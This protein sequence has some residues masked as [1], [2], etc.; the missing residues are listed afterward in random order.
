MDMLNAAWRERALAT[1]KDN[2]AIEI[3]GNANAA[4]TLPVFSFRVKD[5]ENSGYIHQQLVTR[6][7]SDVYGVQARGGCACAG[8]YAHR[9]LGIGKDES[10][11]M[12]A[13]ILS[14]E[15]LKKP[16]WTR[17]N[18]SVL[19]T[20]EK[21]DKIIAAVDEL[22]RTP[23]PMAASYMCDETT[24]RFKAIEQAA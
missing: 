13:G 18:F 9:L 24:A 23:Y 11:A 1:W 7:L 12:R 17:L 22:A 21:A 8:P 5:L 3:L 19:L 16:G 6:M 10:E 15:E 2:P 20:E 4:K 14:G